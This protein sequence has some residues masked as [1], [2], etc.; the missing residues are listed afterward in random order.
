MAEECADIRIRIYRWDEATGAY[1]SRGGA[2]HA[3]AVAPHG[4]RSGNGFTIVA[5]DVSGQVHFLRLEGMTTDGRN[6]R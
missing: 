5:G 4:G 3:C 1:F 6:T 2:L